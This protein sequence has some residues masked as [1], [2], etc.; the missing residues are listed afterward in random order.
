M[1][2]LRT[3]GC[4]KAFISV[5][6]DAFLLTVN[7]NITFQLEYY[8]RAIKAIFNNRNLDVMKKYV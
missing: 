5:N 8:I 7:E 3:D 4:L 2:Q 6:D 1:D